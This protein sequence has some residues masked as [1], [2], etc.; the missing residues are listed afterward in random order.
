M[1]KFFRLMKNEWKKQLRKTATWVMLI[2]LAVC[3]VGYSLIVVQDT[4][5]RYSDYYD[6][7]TLE[8][9][10]QERIKEYGQFVD[11][12]D[13]NGALT[14]FALECRR[15]VEFCEFLIS[16]G[17]TWDD[18]RYTEGLVDFMLDAK[19]MGD[20]AAYLRLHSI[21]EKNDVKGYF[22]FMKEQ[23]GL[24]F[25]HDPQ[26]LAIEEAHYDYCITHDLQPTT[27]DWRFQ[28]ISLVTTS[29]SAI[30]LLERSRDRG[31][32]IDEA[33]LEKAKN[34]L[35]VAEYRLEHDLETNPEECLEAG[36]MEGYSNE[37][38]FWSAMAASDDLVTAIGVFL[39]VIA[40]SIVANEFSQG[41]IKFLL[42]NPVK[43]WKLL[44]A[45]YATV[46]TFGALMTLVLFVLSFLVALLFGDAS[47][48]TAPIVTAEQGVVHTQS[49]MAQ[50][51]L[52][53]L[54][55]GVEVLVMSTMAFAISTLL[56]GSA[57]AIGISLF[58]MLSGSLLVLLLQSFELDWGRYLLFANL[59]LD[60]IARG[61]SMFPHHSL[62]TALVIVVLHMVVFLWTA[63][64]GFVRREV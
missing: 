4:K 47:H 40:G 8:E 36:L 30:L 52:Q 51:L 17:A 59:D 53:Y 20:E 6:Y 39:I 15:T 33:A 5:T 1:R 48:I 3:A 2:L 29:K 25:A 60:A 41:T 14:E 31:E 21:L 64:D 54:L 42:I 35:A 32:Q 62:G 22:T 19:E 13:A 55:A 12:V 46:L 38:S 23:V 24:E 50:V 49:P 56:R 37:S 16:I 34:Q 7:Y 27:R 45:K 43:R 58:S 10:C 11:E 61:A 57:L 28:Q 63:L 26:R 9:D 44:M 18:W